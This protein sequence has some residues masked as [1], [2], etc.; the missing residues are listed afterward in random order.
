MR[1]IPKGTIYDRNGLP[2]ATSNWDE[3]E[4]HRAEYQQLGIDID[5][6]CSRTE[7]RHYPFGGLTVRPAG[8]S[9]HAHPL[10]RQQYVV[11]G[12]RFGAPPAR[13]RRPAHAGGRQESQDRQHR[14]RGALRLSRTG[15]AA[16]PS[17]RSRE[18]RRCG[19]CSTARATCA[20]RSTRACRCGWREILRKQLQ[21][22]GQDKGAAVVLDPATGDLLAAVSYPLPPDRARAA[23]EPAEPRRRRA[24]LPGPRALRP[25]SAR[26]DVQGGDRHG[27]AAQG[28]A[29]GAQTYACIRLPDGRVGNYIKRLEPA[30]PRRRAGHRR[31]TARVDMERGIVVSCNAY[32][33]QL[34]TYDVGAEPLFDTANLLGISTASPNTA[35]AVAQVA[36]AV[37][38]RTG[39]GG[40][41]A[42]PD[43]A[44]GGHGG[45]RRRHAA[46]PL[47][48]RR[49]QRPHAAAAAGADRRTRP[50]RWRGS[51]ARW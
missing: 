42:V 33:A 12:A 4:K 3:L 24:T 27:R 29:A 32:F 36:A 30:H 26:L 17:L 44:R 39:A 21:Q 8:R 20:C 13:L 45:Q 46:G 40:G 1:E 50:P 5:H 10:G 16:A 48:H 51:C 11:R 7:S 19:A 2:L 41:V 31:R 15:A 14:A 47:D 37:V 43:G 22:A 25:L 28:P 9:A 34:G 23:D 38:L 49:D 35:A 6:A 18:S